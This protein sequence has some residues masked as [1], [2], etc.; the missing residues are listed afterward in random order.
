[1][2]SMNQWLGA[3]KQDRRL[4]LEVFLEIQTNGRDLNKAKRRTP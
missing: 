4:G 1:M 3:Q 2:V